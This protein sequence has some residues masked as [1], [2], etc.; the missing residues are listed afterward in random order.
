MLVCYPLIIRDSK[1]EA[2]DSK[3][4]NPLHRMLTEI[5]VHYASRYARSKWPCAGVTSRIVRK[6]NGAT[7]VWLRQQ[8]VRLPI[9]LYISTSL[10]HLDICFSLNYGSTLVWSGPIDFSLLRWLNDAPYHAAFVPII[11]CEVWLVES[12]ASGGIIITLDYLRSSSCHRRW[13]DDYISTWW[14]I[15]VIR[16]GDPNRQSR[17]LVVHRMEMSCA[18]IIARYGDRNCMRAATCWWHQ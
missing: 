1:L 6:M 13:F 3:K 9:N 17:A 8:N 11:N 12:I 5:N 16:I 2:R 7:C 4:R 18:R 14:R 15:I 10:N